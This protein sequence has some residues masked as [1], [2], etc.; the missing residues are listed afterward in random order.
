MIRK[1]LCILFNNSFRLVLNYRIGNFLHNNRGIISNI[2]IMYLRK[3][4]LVK[5][6][7]DISYQSKIG[8]G[9]KFPHPTGIV[10][11][12]GSVIGNNVIIWQQVTLGSDGKNDKSYPIVK[13]KVKLF[14]KCQLIGN[15]TVYE[16]AKVGASSV[17]LQD[18]PKGKTALGI[19][20]KII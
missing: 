13:N 18:V 6:A 7:S 19:P 8:S 15:I 20:A 11:G 5:Y 10:I 12:T 14:A 9:I 17:V 3:K 2:L 1:V 4:Q 16:D